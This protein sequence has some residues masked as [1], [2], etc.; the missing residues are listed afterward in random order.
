MSEPIH[1]QPANR[2]AS[3]HDA[4]HAPGACDACGACGTR[5]VACVLGV[6]YV[7]HI[8]RTVVEVRD[9]ADV[10]VVVW[11]VL[12]DSPVRV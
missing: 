11:Q 8:W 9:H 2:A 5:G 12:F 4:P 1:G 3:V 7:V 10:E 6:C